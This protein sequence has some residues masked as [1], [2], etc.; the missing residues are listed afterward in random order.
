MI[1]DNEDAGSYQSRIMTGGTAADVALRIN[2]N[3]HGDD[4]IAAI[5]ADK[6]FRQA[7]SVAINREEVNEL[8]AKGLGIPMQWT[9]NHDLP[10]YDEAWG[11]AY[12]AYDPAQA[13]ALLDAMGMTERDG[14]GYRMTPS[15]K[16]F[17][18]TFDVADNSTM[19]VKSS[20]LL[21]E[22]WEAVGIRV[23]LNIGE[24]GALVQKLISKEWLAFGQEV[25]GPAS[26]LEMLISGLEGWNLVGHLQR[27]VA[28]E[29]HRRRG[30]HRAAG[31]DQAHLRDQQHAPDG[32][33]GDGDRM[34]FKEAYD[35]VADTVPVIGVLGYVG[36]PIIW[37]T[38][39]G[40]VDTS[41]PVTRIG[42]MRAERPLH[43]LLEELG[44]ASDPTPGELSGGALRGAALHL[45]GGAAAAH[46]P[47]FVHHHPVAAGG[48]PVH[49]DGGHAAARGRDQP[50]R[51]GTAAEAVRPRPAAAGALPQVAV[52]PGVSRRPWGSRSSGTSRSPR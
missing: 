38:D 36:K 11:N 20:E 15:G 21:A 50:R 45:H 18:F 17:L 3:Y 42:G 40:N 33:G 48:L 49:G 44:R 28:L 27:L 25:G 7:L 51:G 47:G 2:W 24:L 41:L 19:T 35:W 43:L 8:I 14:D 52:R 6:R 29:F 30:R 12:A 46:L 39:L 32:A 37:K 10:Y 13:D 16:S 23:N 26:T 5:L 1:R 9:A 4:E 22:Y 31:P 34:A